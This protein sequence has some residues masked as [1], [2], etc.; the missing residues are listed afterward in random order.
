MGLVIAHNKT[1]LNCIVRLASGSN[2]TV[3]LQPCLNVESIIDYRVYCVE[4]KP[5][6]SIART[7]RQGEVVANVGLGGSL[8][9]IETPPD[10]SSQS[11]LIASLIG[12]P[13]SSIDFLFDGQDY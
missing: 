12:L 3:I 2:M 4:C 1:E 8:R 11:G 9:V 7:A 13:Y 6:T 5:H 10:L